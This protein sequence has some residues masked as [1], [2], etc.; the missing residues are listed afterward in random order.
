M[1]YYLEALITL[2]I[3]YAPKKSRYVKESKI[4]IVPPGHYIKL[5]IKTGNIYPYWIYMS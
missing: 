1:K 4:R 2:R 3:T 5:F